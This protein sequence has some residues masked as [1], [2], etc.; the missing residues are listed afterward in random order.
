MAISL[1][2]RNFKGIK[3]GELKLDPF[4]ILVGSNNS[5]KT[6]VLESLFLLANPFRGILGTTVLDIIVKS[7]MLI[8][9]QVGASFLF[10]GY[11]SKKASIALDGKELIMYRDRSNNT[12]FSLTGTG[13]PTRITIDGNDIEGNWIGQVNIVGNKQFYGGITDQP[14]ETLLFNSYVLRYAFNYFRDHW[15]E[16]ANSDIPRRVAEELSDFSYEKYTNFT[17]EPFLAGIYTMYALTASGMRVR[18]SDLGE[19][20]QIYIAVKLMYDLIKPKTLLW[21]DIEAHLNPRMLVKIAGWLHDLVNSGVNVIVTTHSMEAVK[22]VAGIVNDAQIALLSL[23]DGK[24]KSHE[25]KLSEVEEL[26]KAGIDV[27]FAEGYL[28]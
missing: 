11:N 4:T 12:F 26:Q 10:N 23:E 18:I 25:M 22:S 21:D 1:K 3:E 2:L 8:E 28:F 19:G 13:L 15:I 14:V 5:A 17:I 24:L 7:H 9:N 27:R 16:L 20:M 6:T